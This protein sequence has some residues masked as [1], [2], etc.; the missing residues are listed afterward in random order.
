MLRYGRE[1]FVGV[2]AGAFLGAVLYIG[3]ALPALVA[4]NSIVAQLLPVALL[5]SALAGAL[6]GVVVVFG[7]LVAL[8]IRDRELDAGSRARQKAA[9]YGAPIGVVALAIGLW[10]IEG[11]PSVVPVSML[12]LIAICALLA[13]WGARIGVRHADARVEHAAE[14]ETSRRR[15]SI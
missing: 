5:V 4:G 13:A 1:S 6:V 7:V 15:V 14:R 8:V 12:A 2:V 11:A 10:L 9:S 3:A